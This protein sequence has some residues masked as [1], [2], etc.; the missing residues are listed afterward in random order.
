M[1]KT[2]L[3]DV[4]DDVAHALREDI[5]S[6]DL[7]GQLIAESTLIDGTI[8]TREPMTLAGQPWVDEVCRQVDPDIGVNWHFADGDALDAGAT[9]CTMQ[10]PA[11][12][13][14]V[15]ERTA[16]NFLQLLSATATVTTQYVQAVTGTDC[17][18]L[19]T[20]KTI[21]GLRLAQKYAVRCGGGVNHRIGTVQG[22][23]GEE[24]GR[25][26]RDFFRARRH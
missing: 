16:L 5:G 11:R 23:G 6:G 21:P 9:L 10:G 20:R 8:I 12:S 19:D 22:P 2:L 1:N 26:L 25:L 3:A 18:I 17:R 15:A 24:S 14:L 7:S 4:E 13:I